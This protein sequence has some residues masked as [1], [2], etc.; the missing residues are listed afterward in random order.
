MKE[1]I[2]GLE[3]SSD[4]V[5]TNKERLLGNAEWVRR[6]LKQEPSLMNAINAI[7]DTNKQQEAIT[8]LLKTLT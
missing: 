4:F 1:K 8:E 2:L 7:T 3:S 6:F 5:K